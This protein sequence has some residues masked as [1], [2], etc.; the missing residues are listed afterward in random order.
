MDGK[1]TRSGTF[2]YVGEP[3]NTRKGARVGRGAKATQSSGAIT[4]Y[5]GVAGTV[6]T[7]AQNFGAATTTTGTFG[8]VSNSTLSNLTS[9]S[10]AW[11]S[12]VGRKN[13]AKGSTI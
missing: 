9:A 5:G 3:I 7:S 8:A 6:T 12:I 2:N 11:W 10:S 13:L 4:T 1:P